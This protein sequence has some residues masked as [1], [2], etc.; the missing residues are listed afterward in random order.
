LHSS[1]KHRC[2]NT[3]F[4]KFNNIPASSEGF[5]SGEFVKVGKDEGHH[6]FPMDFSVQVD[7]K[8][9][10]SFSTL[11]NRMFRHFYLPNPSSKAN[12]QLRFEFTAPAS[13][14]APS[15]K[16]VC[17]ISLKDLPIGMRV[18]ETHKL[19]PLTPIAAQGAPL[20]DPQLQLQTSIYIVH[21]GAKQVSLIVHMHVYTNVRMCV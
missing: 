7:R 11:D 9:I 2:E 6:I 19:E 1:V 12:A 18:V 8:G 5:C 13:M 14:A 4:R 15:E 17:V 3:V 16:F 10:E 21:G 20:H